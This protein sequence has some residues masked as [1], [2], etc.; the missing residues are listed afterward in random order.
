[1]RQLGR[2]L[3][4]VVFLIGCIL[5]ETTNGYVYTLG[6]LLIIVGLI[7]GT[8]RLFSPSIPED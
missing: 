3:W 6:A 7:D 1:M 4:F 8:L 5:T 2:G